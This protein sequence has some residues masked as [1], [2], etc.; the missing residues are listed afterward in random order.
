MYG[1]ASVK[2]KKKHLLVQDETMK[3][4]S[5]IMMKDYFVFSHALRGWMSSAIARLNVSV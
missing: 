2:R 1:V 3:M 4:A 5:R